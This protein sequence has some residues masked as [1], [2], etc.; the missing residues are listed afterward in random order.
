[1]QEKKYIPSGAYLTGIADFP[2]LRSTGCIYV[3]KT[4]LIHESTLKI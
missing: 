1:M 3:D 2:K 4:Y